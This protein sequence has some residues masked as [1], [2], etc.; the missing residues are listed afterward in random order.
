MANAP[1]PTLLYGIQINFNDTQKSQIDALVA[2]TNRC[3][4]ACNQIKAALEQ[5]KATVTGVLD[6]NGV[7][8]IQDN[9]VTSTVMRIAVP[10]P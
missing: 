1:D 2:D 9:Q 4:A 6:S 3:T 5:F 7:A 10:W 8:G